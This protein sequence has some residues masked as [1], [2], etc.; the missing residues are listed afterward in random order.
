MQLLR[1]IIVKCQPK[2]WMSSEVLKD[3]LA[4]AKGDSKKAGD[5]SVGRI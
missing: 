4:M 5:A 1:Q 3:W 2:G